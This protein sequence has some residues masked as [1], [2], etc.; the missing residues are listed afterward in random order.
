MSSDNPTPSPSEFDAVRRID[1]LCDQ[2]EAD[3]RAGKGTRIEELLAQ[4]PPHERR[5]L[6]TELL[7]VEREVLQRRGQRPNVAEYVARFGDRRDQDTS[8]SRWPHLRF[9]PG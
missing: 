7:K 6:L 4:V 2:Y 9:G 1:S 5:S 8:P 3:A